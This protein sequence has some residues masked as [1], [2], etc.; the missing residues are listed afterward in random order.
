[1]EINPWQGWCER[2]KLDYATNNRVPQFR[3]L[4]DRPL[5]SAIAQRKQRIK[6]CAVEP[7]LFGVSVIT[8]GGV[9]LLRITNSWSA[10]PKGLLPWPL[11]LVGR[12]YSVEWGTWGRGGD[13]VRRGCRRS[14][15]LGNQQWAC[16]LPARAV[17]GALARTQ[18]F[19]A[20]RASF[21]FRAS[22]PYSLHQ[23]R[24]PAQESV[25]ATSPAL[26]FRFHP[27][28]SLPSLS[29]LLFSSKLINFGGKCWTLWTKSIRGCA[30]EFV[31]TGGGEGFIVPELVLITIL[32]VT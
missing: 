12:L 18:C 21:S 8:L 25:Q 29:S 31:G 9:S 28:P 6:I 30:V 14:V 3:F 4:T 15:P 1:M 2:R 27:Q 24:E 11:Y 20:C 26:H 16:N 7:Y 32:L 17:R 5:G 13:D 19:Q 23:A 10:L 22:G